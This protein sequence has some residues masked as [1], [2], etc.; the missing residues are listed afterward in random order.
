MRRP[1]NWRNKSNAIG[2]LLIF[3]ALWA[4]GI[5]R[6]IPVEDEVDR[7]VWVIVDTTTGGEDANK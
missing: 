2:I 7:H 4:I 3:L 1:P 5:S 6:A